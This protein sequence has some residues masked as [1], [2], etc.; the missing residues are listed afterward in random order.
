MTPETRDK[1]LRVGAKAIVAALARHGVRHRAT[2]RLPATD[3]FAGD[4]A[5]ALES[6]RA[7]SVL[8]ADGPSA[9]H[10]ERLAKR[11][12]AGIVARRELGSVPVAAGDAILRDRDTMVV[13][14]APLADQVAEEAA[15]AIAFEEFT[16]E[17]VNQ[18]GGVYGLHIPSGERAKA[19][20]A[21]WRRMRGR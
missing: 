13:I 9:L 14:P 19:A 5:L 18:G 11:G 3:P 21:Q 7:G 10:R 1:L 4:A 2:G 12:I 6:C 17:Q 20:F 16:A 15:E 8:V